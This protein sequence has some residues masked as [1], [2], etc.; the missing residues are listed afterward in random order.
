VFIDIQTHA[1]TLSVQISHIRSPLLILRVV[2]PAD[3]FQ[4]PRRH[5][6]ALQLPTLARQ[7]ASTKRRECAAKCVE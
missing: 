3:A 7:H 5:T 6:N 4:R 1:G 2:V